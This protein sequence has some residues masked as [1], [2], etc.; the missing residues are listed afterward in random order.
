[1]SEHQPGHDPE[2][3]HEHAHGFNSFL[4]RNWGAIVIAFG[5]VFVYILAHYNPT[6]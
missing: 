6:N 3:A 4:D 2:G 1:M 5:C